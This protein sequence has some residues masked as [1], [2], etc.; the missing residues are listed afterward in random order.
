MLDARRRGRMTKPYGN[1]G[2]A[3]LSSRNGESKSR[4]RRKADARIR[5]KLVQISRSWPL[6]EAKRRG[7]QILSRS[8][9]AVE[10][11]S[12]VNR[13]TRP[14]S[15]ACHEATGP[16]NPPLRQLHVRRKELRL[17]GRQGSG[18][19]NLRDK[20]VSSRD[21]SSRWGD[22]RYL[23]CFSDWGLAM[24]AI[25]HLPSALRHTRP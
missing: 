25:V 10:S 16:Q 15:N 18:E 7:S 13:E 20:C 22:G 1:D 19:S 8:Y 5:K 3:R 24:K 11:N 6:K 2:R 4:K 23:G 9:T 14:Q 17:R 21:Y 12:F